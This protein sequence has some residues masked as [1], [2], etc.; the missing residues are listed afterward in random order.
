MAATSRQY[1]AVK[2]GGPFAFAS[3]PK[4]TPGPN[5]VS[6]RIKAIGLNPVDCKRLQYGVMVQS[7]PAVFGIDGAGTVEA[8]GDGVTSVKPGDEVMAMCTGKDGSAFQEIAVVSQ[9]YV[10]KKPKS[11][12]FEEAA[13]LP[14]V[15][16]AYS[17]KDAKTSPWITDE[18]V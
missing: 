2:Q 13:S 6:V 18:H 7:W 8:V 14:Y 4:P 15:M 12:N 9:A 5:E 1:Q 11:L 17:Q 10:S 3:I 16:T